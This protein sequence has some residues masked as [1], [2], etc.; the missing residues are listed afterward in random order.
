MC[1]GFKRRTKGLRGAI[2]WELAKGSNER[3][4]CR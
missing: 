4:N 3:V 1:D 2:E